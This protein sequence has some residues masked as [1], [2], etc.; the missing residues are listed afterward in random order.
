[1]S[2]TLA[3]GRGCLVVHVEGKLKAEQPRKALLKSKRKNRSHLT[4]Y[5]KQIPAGRVLLYFLCISHFFFSLFFLDLIWKLDILFF[6]F[7]ITAPPQKLF[8]KSSSIYQKFFKKKPLQPFGAIH[9]LRRRVF[10]LFEPLLPPCR[11]L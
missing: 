5:C 2:K 6:L 11:L 8:Y 4:N 10:G 1:M 3:L 7:F 9:K